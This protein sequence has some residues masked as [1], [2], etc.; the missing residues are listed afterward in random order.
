LYIDEEDEKN[1]RINGKNDLSKKTSGFPEKLND[2][3]SF[4]PTEARKGMDTWDESIA[5]GKKPPTTKV[6]PMQKLRIFAVNLTMVGD[7]NGL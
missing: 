4:S 2:K 1:E 7:T 6:N 3:E 5:K